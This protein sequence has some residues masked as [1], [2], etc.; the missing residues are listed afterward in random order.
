VA[1]KVPWGVGV[2]GAEEA[3]TALLDRWRWQALPFGLV[4][5]GIGAACFGVLVTAAETIAA[6]K[7]ALTLNADVGP[8]S[9]KTTLAVVLW[10]VAWGLLLTELRR[11]R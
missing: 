1:Q 4:G 7:T 6:V 10:L 5:A 8:L 3:F 11:A 9:G 2:G